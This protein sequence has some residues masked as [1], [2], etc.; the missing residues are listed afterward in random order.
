MGRRGARAKAT[1]RKVPRSAGGDSARMPV[2]NV[3]WDD[4]QAYTRWLSKETG[5]DYRLPSESEWEYAASAGS[6]LPYWWGYKPEPGRAH[7]INCQTDYPSK[8]PAPVGSFKP[9]P[10]GLLDTAGKVLEWV[11]DCYHQNYSGA[12]GDSG[13]FEGGDCSKRVARGGA[14]NTPSTSMRNQRRTSF[15]STRP[16]TNI[17]FR[18]ARDL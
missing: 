11:H 3:R 2:V 14:F 1:G 13:V 17:G 4:A 6:G 18:V 16:R 12:P 10:F 5:A 15:Q 8:G 7:C 9:N